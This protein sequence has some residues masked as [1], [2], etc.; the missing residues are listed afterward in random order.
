MTFP[1]FRHASVSFLGEMYAKI[2]KKGVR[3]I[4]LVRFVEGDVNPSDVR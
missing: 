3:I 1:T 4:L 2:T